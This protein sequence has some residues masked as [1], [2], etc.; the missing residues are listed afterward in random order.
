[1]NRAPIP[2]NS[3]RSKIRRSEEFQAMGR[4]VFVSSKVKCK[5]LGMIYKAQCV[6]CW[7]YGKTTAGK[8]ETRDDCKKANR[9]NTKK[10]LK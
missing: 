6:D 7:H 5:I 2:D 3:A 10:C 8:Y 4:G 9:G 1:M